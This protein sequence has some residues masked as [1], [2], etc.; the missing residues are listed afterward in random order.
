M[1]RAA[2]SWGWSAGSESSASGGLSS[3]RDGLLACGV[4]GCRPN[5]GGVLCALVDVGCGLSSEGVLCIFCGGVLCA[6]V[7]GCLDLNPPP[8]TPDT[9]SRNFSSGA[10]TSRLRVVGATPEA[11]LQPLHTDPVAGFM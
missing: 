8:V 6:L 7:A 10:S 1:A 3:D 5:C 2:E 4:T 9:C 11:V